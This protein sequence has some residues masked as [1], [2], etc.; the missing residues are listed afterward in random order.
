MNSIERFETE[1]I[2]EIRRH[3]TKAIGLMLITLD[4]VKNDEHWVGVGDLNGFGL[5]F[6]DTLA[7]LQRIDRIM[8]DD[9]Q[10]SDYR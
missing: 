8:Y 4:E 9:M 7:E 10:E 2:H 3:I 5:P 6:E 1:T